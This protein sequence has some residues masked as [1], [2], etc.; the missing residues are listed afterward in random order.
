M[1]SN[2]FDRYDQ[3]LSSDCD[4]VYIASPNNLHYSNAMSA[5]EYGKHV[6]LEKPMTLSYEDSK[7]LVGKAEEKHLIIAVKSI[8]SKSPSYPFCLFRIPAVYRIY[9]VT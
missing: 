4:A 1:G 9:G 8:A 5:L 7:K 2:A 6:L 3:M